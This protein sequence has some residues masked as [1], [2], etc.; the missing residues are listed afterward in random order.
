MLG[1]SLEDPSRLTGGSQETPGCSHETPRRLSGGSRRLS[2]GFKVIY[3]P[4]VRCLPR[5]QDKGSI[6]CMNAL[7]DGCF[8]NECRIV[9]LQY[10]SSFILD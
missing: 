1:G 3:V 10:W 5:R 8:E 7:E 6:D 4:R 2:G 9:L